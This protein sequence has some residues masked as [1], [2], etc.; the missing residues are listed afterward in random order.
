LLSLRE[1]ADWLVVT[2]DGLFDGSKAAWVKVLWR[3]SSSM[4]DVAPLERF[5]NEFHYPG[6]LAEILAGKGP[7]APQHLRR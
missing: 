2:P 7:K 5:F 6:L 3:F 4:F 1:G